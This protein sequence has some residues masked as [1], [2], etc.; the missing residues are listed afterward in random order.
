MLIIYIL[1][2]RDHHRKHC[3]KFDQNTLKGFIPI[4]FKRLNIRIEFQTLT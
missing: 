3:A 2:R 1:K 4:I